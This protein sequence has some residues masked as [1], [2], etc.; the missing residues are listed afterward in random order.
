VNA[1]EARTTA[2]SMPCRAMKRRMQRPTNVVS[3]RCTSA[4]RS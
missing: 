2:R 4:R 3:S 1:C